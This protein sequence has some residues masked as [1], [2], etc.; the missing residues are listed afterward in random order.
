[1]TSVGALYVQFSAH[2]NMLHNLLIK[3]YYYTLCYKAIV[4]ITIRDGTSLDLI[5]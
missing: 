5:V 3:I 4:C 1:M 2:I